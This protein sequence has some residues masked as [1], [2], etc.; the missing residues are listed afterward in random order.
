MPLLGGLFVNLFS[1]LVA[2]LSVYVSR[3]VAFGLAA[4][5]GMTGLTAALF[6]LFRT[7][8][9]QLA[10][11]THGANAIFLDAIAMAIP[12]VAPACISTYMTMWTACTVYV[13]QRD[14]LHL[15]AK[16]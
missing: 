15:F 8:V 9:T 13:W 3:K 11:M 14:L 7:T 10:S 4:V 5:A 1:G 16:T 6:V 2:W 12:P